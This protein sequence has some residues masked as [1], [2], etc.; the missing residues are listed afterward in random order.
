MLLFD[1]A[2]DQ[3]LRR[4]FKKLISPH[5]SCWPRSLSE[6]RRLHRGAWK[7]PGCW[8]RSSKTKTVQRAASTGVWSEASVH[9]R[10]GSGAAVGGLQDAG[11]DWA[12]QRLDPGGL[13]GLLWGPCE[14]T[15]ALP[16]PN[17]LSR[18]GRGLTCRDGKQAGHRQ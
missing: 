5:L 13:A 14:I 6:G 8:L 17:T 11:L 4:G 1:L 9:R 10:A 16:L 18:G 15:E 3:E 7:G 2:S 12:P